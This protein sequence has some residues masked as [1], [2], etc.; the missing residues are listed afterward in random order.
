MSRIAVS[1]NEMTIWSVRLLPII[2]SAVSL[3]P[4]PIAI[5]ALGAPPVLTK[6][7]KAETIIITDIHTPKPVRARSPH[8]GM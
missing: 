2:F 5:D 1:T 7:E 8:S 3:S 4:R 6:A